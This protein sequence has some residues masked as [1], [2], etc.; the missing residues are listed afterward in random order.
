M[1]APASPNNQTRQEVT[2]YLTSYQAFNYK[3]QGYPCKAGSCS[4]GL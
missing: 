4:E 1:L 2:R 3:R